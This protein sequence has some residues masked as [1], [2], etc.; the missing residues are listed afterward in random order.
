M[1]LE[2]KIN[3]DLRQA[4]LAKDELRVS[5]LRS[6]KSSLLYFKVAEKLDREQPLDDQKVEAV[7]SKESKKRQESAD[8]YAKGGS[9]DR[10]QAELAEKKIIDT[11]LPQP[12]S[13]ADLQ[14]VVDKAIKEIKPDGPKDM[15]K[16]IGFV[17]QQVGVAADGSAIAKLVKSSLQ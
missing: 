15:G 11:Y 17:K 13:E 9:Q 12:M 10:A 6:L 16:V 4:M 7:L 3:Q 14:Q 8:L 2:D 5:V 1:S